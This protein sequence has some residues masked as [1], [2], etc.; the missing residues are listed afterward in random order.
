MD[1]NIKH[2]IENNVFSTVVTVDSLGTEL[3]S[4]DEEKELLH[5]FPSKIAYKNL[6]FTRNVKMNGSL[7]EVTSEEVT[8]DTSGTIVSVSVPPLSNKE[9]LVDENFEATYRIDVSK[10]S[11]SAIDEN[12]LTSAELVAQAYCIVYDAVIC[13]A[14]TDIMK[15][16]REKAPMFSGE[17]V[18]N[19]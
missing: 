5:D 11:S 10:I 13:D 1:L 8:D 19:I 17:S 4:E 6:S 16:I 12:V 14:V 2:D 3:L 15:S 7:P 18:V 9:I